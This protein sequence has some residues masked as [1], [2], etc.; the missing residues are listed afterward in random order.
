MIV[1]GRTLRGDDADPRSEVRRLPDLRRPRRGPR[2][3]TRPMTVPPCATPIG[4]IDRA[5][6]A[7]LRHRGL[8]GRGL[9]EPSCAQCRIRFDRLRRRL[10]PSSIPPNG[11]MTTINSFLDHDSL[12][13][14]GMSVTMPHKAPGATGSRARRRPRRGLRDLRRCEHPGGRRRRCA[15]GPEHR[16]T[17]GD[18]HPRRSDGFDGGPGEQS[19]AVIGASGVAARSAPVPLAQGVRHGVQRTETRGRH[20]VG[21]LAERIPDARIELR[22]IAVDRVLRGVHQLP[23]WATDGSDPES[24]PLPRRWSS[25]ET[26]SSSTPFWRRT[27]TASAAG[28]GGRPASRPSGDVHPPGGAPV[29]GV[30][31]GATCGR[32]L[33]QH[34]RGD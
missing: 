29:R 9:H 12:D 28:T 5:G 22:T 20:M 26:W 34:P 16:R 14:S 10:S 33:R 18:R 23:R 2:D 8:A 4:S 19:V 3:R 32:T 13:F 1:L 24:S 30:D 21:D 25:T 17:R 15:H 7:G 27:D 6:D 31:R 11:S